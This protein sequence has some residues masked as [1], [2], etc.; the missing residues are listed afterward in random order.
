[1][2]LGHFI[3]LAVGLAFA[4]I[5]FAAAYALPLR[6][7]A[8]ALIIL[9]PFELINSQYGTSSTGLVYLVT[10]ALFLRKELRHFP[11]LGAVSGIMMVYTLSL[12]TANA[13]TFDHILYLIRILPGFLLFYIAYN[14]VRNNQDP[15]RFLTILLAINILVLLICTLQLIGGSQQMVLFGVQEFALMANRNTQERLSGP[16]GAE[17]TSEYLALASLLLAYLNMNKK[18]GQRWP[19]WLLWAM[20]AANIGFMVATGSRGGML[21]LVIG[22]FWGGFL[23][24]RFLGTGRILGFL[25]GIVLIGG[26][27]T[28]V[29]IQFTEFNVFLNRVESTEV[30]DGVLDTRSK[31]WPI[32]WEAIKEKPILGYGPRLR[33]HFDMLQRI[34]GH[35]PIPYPHSLPLFLLYTLG[36][37]GLVA[38]T[39]FFALLLKRLYA[40]SKGRGTPELKGLSSLG[41]LLLAVFLIDEIKIEFLRF[42]QSDYQ[43]IIFTT[44]GGFLAMADRA[45]IRAKVSNSQAIIPNKTNTQDI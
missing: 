15:I 4:V 35:T 6:I 37:V 8:P 38:Y 45:R 9:A 32:A 21:V 24:R 7:V 27:M 18:L 43:A 17:F 25:L 41:F 13:A 29:M 2:E 26:I 28:T 10:L 22:L 42:I 14:Y 40:G 34:P 44:L 36:I 1:M 11:L 19:T 3:Q 30:K 23:F 16:F 20:L 33:L 12:V 5:A 39:V 31:T